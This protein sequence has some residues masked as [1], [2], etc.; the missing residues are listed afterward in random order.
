VICKKA[1]DRIKEWKK[2]LETRVGSKESTTFV[3]GD[4]PEELIEDVAARI[5]AEIELEAEEENTS[6]GSDID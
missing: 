3:L 1:P 2:A 4:E 6:E 5:A